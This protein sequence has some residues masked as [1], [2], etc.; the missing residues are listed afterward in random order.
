[1]RLNYYKTTARRLS[2]KFREA[3]T[4]FLSFRELGVVLLSLPD[5]ED[6]L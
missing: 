4:G 3:R 6:K 2:E 1:M 5:L